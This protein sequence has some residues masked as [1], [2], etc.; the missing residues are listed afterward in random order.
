MERSSYVTGDRHL[1]KLR[2]T[3]ES[4]S[5]FEDH[6]KVFDVPPQIRS[7]EA[8]VVVLIGTERCEDRLKKVFR[9]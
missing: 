3:D 1:F 7:E 5:L 2:V 8:G 6:S 4:K 9:N